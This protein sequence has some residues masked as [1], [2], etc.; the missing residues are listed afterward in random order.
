MT[1]TDA[2]AADIKP[3]ITVAEGLYEVI[4]H[5]V[6]R[7][8]EPYAA[9]TYLQ[10]TASRSAV[11]CETCGP[12]PVEGL[13]DWTS[14]WITLCGAAMDH[15]KETGHMVAVES[16]RGAVYGPEREAT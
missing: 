3:G 10:E 16:W 15:A 7:E 14:D 1:V 9:G 8:G 6:H 2:S 13:R 12:L 5:R 4:A 11:A